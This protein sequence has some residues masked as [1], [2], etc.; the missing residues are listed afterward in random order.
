MHDKFLI[1][2]WCMKHASEWA[3]GSEGQGNL[4][5]PGRVKELM[6]VNQGCVI[7]KEKTIVFAPRAPY[8]SRE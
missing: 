6:E 8:H 5:G 3:N 4:S 2:W 7:K 1:L